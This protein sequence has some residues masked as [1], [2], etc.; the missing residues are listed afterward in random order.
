MQ[1]T[2]DGTN[3][4]D[5]GTIL[6]PLDQPNIHEV[7][8]FTDPAS[9]NS[10]IVYAYRVVAMNTVGYGAEFPAMNVQS[11]SD[12]MLT[13]TAPADPTNLTAVAQAGPQV[14]LTFTDN[15]I[16]ETGF[17]IQRAVNGGAWA[18]LTTR[19][20]RVATG[21]VTYTDTA[22]T[23]GNTYAYRVRADRGAAVSAWSNTATVAVP[24]TITPSAGANGS[25]TPGTATL[26]ASGG[27]Q[28]F[29]IMPNAGYQRDTVKVDGVDQPAA[30][31]SGTYTFTNVTANHTISAT[32]VVGV[33]SISVTAPP[34]RR[35]LR[36]EL[37]P[38]GDLD[39][40]CGGLCR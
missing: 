33:A 19:P 35:Q 26:V 13:G 36:P 1:R 37:Q 12:P 29:S 24:Y 11:V 2:A 20:A 34:A 18:L 21:N 28:A 22:V 38:T 25:I 4:T 16:N 27:S 14:L 7:R 23:A 10:T 9:Y 5:Q 40:Q 17:T 30:V 8:T 15:A 39:D 3:W 6:S 32:F 31:T